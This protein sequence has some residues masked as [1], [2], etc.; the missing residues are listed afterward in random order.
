MNKDSPR[1]FDLLCPHFNEC[2]GCSLNLALDRPPVLDEMRKWFD[3]QG[4]NDFRLHALKAS[5][6]RTRAKL[7]VRGSSDKPQIG[8]YEAGTHKV[9]DIPDCRVHHPAINWGVDA[10]KGLIVRHGITLYD[11]VTGV[12]DLRY[13][14]FIVERSTGK[15]HISFVL[16]VHCKDTA[17]LDVWQ[18]V[19]GE[20]WEDCGE[21]SLHS[22][23]VNMNVRRDNVI[24][25]GEWKLLFGAP[26]LW[27]TFLGVD[28]CFQPS[29]FAQA[30]LD[31][32]ECL[33]KTVK[34]WVPEKARVAEYYAGVGVIGLSVAEKSVR[35]RCCEINAQ[36]VECF[37]ESRR[38]LP[39]EVAEKIEWA[40]GESTKYIN[41]LS[42]ADVIIVD[43]PRKGVEP[44]FLQALEGVKST[45]Q[46][47][48]VSCGLQSFRRD[49]EALI[50]AGW[51]L[52]KGEGHLFFPGSDHIETVALFRKER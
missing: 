20:M 2:S 13:L 16:N 37:D 36:A 24:F 11:E 44:K 7:A 47:V 23:A 5:A 14:Q 49:A 21:S 19:L 26:L 31:Q 28:V 39:A 46:L 33:L 25:G 35:V 9:V 34:E 18:K 15:L 52:K 17:K 32:F 30:N 48:Y 22:L 41:W 38:R 42:D 10:I 50:R 6:W 12:G 51:C 45:A 43:P 8:L 27:E 1:L 29:S 4:V 3:E 40:P